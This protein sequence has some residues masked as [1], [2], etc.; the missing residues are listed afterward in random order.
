[1]PRKPL[2]WLRRAV[3]IPRRVRDPSARLVIASLRGSNPK[4]EG[5]VRTC[6]WLG[7]LLWSVAAVGNAAEPP[8]YYADKSS[9]TRQ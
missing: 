3:I 1:M 4:A 6:F 2:D 7:L 5:L 9:G 8:W